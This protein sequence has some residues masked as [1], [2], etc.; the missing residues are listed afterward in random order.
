VWNYQYA[1][2]PLQHIVIR[3]NIS[4]GDARRHAYGGIHIGG[5]GEPLRDIE[6]Y[7]NTVVVDPA[8]RGARGAWVGG[9]RHERIRFWNNLL[10]ATGPALLVD[11]SA[12]QNDVVFQGNAYRT[13]RGP[14][15]VLDHSKTFAGLDR[16]RTSTGQEMQEGQA[17]GMYAGPR[18]RAA[19]W[20]PTISGAA[21]GPAS[22]ARIRERSGH[23][24]PD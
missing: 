7:R 9:V 13:Q 21:P 19:P 1:P 5:D 8:C 12:V 22:E 14:F 10:V 2:R 24:T 20:G 6:V 11:I 3:Y 18:P 15:A 4:S 17:R 16:W 23:E